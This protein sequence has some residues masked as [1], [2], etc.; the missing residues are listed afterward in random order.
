M[1][2]KTL[3]ESRMRGVTY[4]GEVVAQGQTGKYGFRTGGRV[5]ESL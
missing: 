1:G 4:E 5:L 2:T 3:E